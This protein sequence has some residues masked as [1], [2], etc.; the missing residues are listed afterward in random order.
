ME[1]YWKRFGANYADRVDGVLIGHVVTQAVF[2]QDPRYFYKGKGS[3]GSRALYAI[4][5][6]FVSKGDNGHWQP[7]Y[8]DVLGGM[9]SYELS[10]LYR[11]GTSRPG[12][13]LFHTF[14]LGFSGR[15]S[16]N[17]V[18]EF[19]M[20]KITKHVPKLAAQSGP[21]LHAGT[22]VSLISVEDLSG[23]TAE[24]GGPIEF[25]LAGDLRVDGAVIAKA[26]AQAW[27]RV[28]Y[29]AVPGANGEVR[30]DLERVHLTVGTVD[31]PLR[32]TAVSGG[33][34]SIEYHRLENS[35]RIVIVL[36]ADKDVALAPAD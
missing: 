28:N 30:V 15:A 14:L 29:D 7:A 27:G 25:V 9:A 5:T 35:G 12:L 23:K 22:P 20:R 21:V 32:S 31:V 8:A 24:K 13:R 10:T 4:A 36:Y 3:F 16:Q 17:L 2:R 19:I 6:A 1:G 11:P 18:Q 33:A 34:G 26:G